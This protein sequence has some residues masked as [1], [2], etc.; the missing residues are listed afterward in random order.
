MEE[1]G[2]ATWNGR[3]GEEAG[4]RM[5]EKGRPSKEALLDILMTT[6]FHG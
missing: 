6:H 5:V 3:G 1:T 2:A 4:A